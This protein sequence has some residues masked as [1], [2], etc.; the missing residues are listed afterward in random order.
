MADRSTDLLKLHAWLSP[1]Y[2]VG[3]YTY[4]HGLEQAVSAGDVHDA[5]STQAWIVDVLEMGSGRNDAILLAHAWR[6]ANDPDALDELSELTHAFAPSAERLLETRAQGAAFADVTEAA[7]GDEATKNAPYP[8]ALGAAAGRAEINLRLT[9][10]LFLQAFASN[11]VS[12]AI[13]LVPLGQTDGQRIIAALGP[14]C[15]QIAEEAT[16]ADL[17]DLGGCAVLADI[18]SM[19]HETQDVRLFRS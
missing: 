17:D 1:A 9:A 8:V 11:L 13:R 5:V 19:R 10:P 15:Q 18:A 14:L 16:D 7:W 6:A 2:P 3:A 4:S 12:A